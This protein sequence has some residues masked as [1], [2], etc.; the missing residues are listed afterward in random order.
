M[1]SPTLTESSC[2]IESL[3]RENLETTACKS[4][5]LS[6]NEQVQISHPASKAAL[7][8]SYEQVGVKE[9]ASSQIFSISIENIETMLALTIASIGLML[10]M[11]NK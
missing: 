2:K 9:L 4:K 8:K 11:L 7:I 1:I 5:F 6:P 3:H 10:T